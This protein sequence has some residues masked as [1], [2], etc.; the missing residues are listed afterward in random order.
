MIAYFL[1]KIQ[2][3]S[4]IWYCIRRKFIAKYY[5]KQECKDCLIWCICDLEDYDDLEE[6]IDK[7]D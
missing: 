6:G 4:M 5:E 1:W 3:C 7:E 2:L